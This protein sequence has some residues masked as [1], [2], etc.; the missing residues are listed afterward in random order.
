MGISRRSFL[1]TAALAGLAANGASGSEKM[2]TRILGRTGARVSILGFG[3]GSRFLMYKDEEK[4][5]AA[6]NRAL[7]LGINYVD[8]AYVYGDGVSETWV[9]QVMK[10]RRKEAWL[11]TKIHKRNGDEA[12]RIIEGSLKRL[13][14]DHVDL[15][16]VHDL[17]EDDDLKAIE[18]KDGV[19]NL[20]Y[21][22]R[23]QKVARFI[24]VT[25]HHNPHSLKAALEH[26]D[27][28]CTQMALNAARVGPTKGFA[29]PF[30]ECFENIALPVAQSKKMGITAM[31]IFGQE[32]LVGEASPEKL[33][34]YV[35]SLP[36]AAAIIGM[37]KLD[38]L[39]Q[40]V[41]V[42]KSF[43][44]MPHDEMKSLAAELSS[45][46]KLAMDRY[47]QNHVDC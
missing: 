3:C 25:C 9:G 19:L 4:G 10:T 38:H 26:N 34:R 41:T 15:L 8:S 14:T 24:G 36:V 23:E 5:V 2:P 22:L 18:A 16:H 37:P 21:K 29:N 6:L 43:K 11:V 1:G 46:H 20:L 7:D 42:A 13:Q 31:K 44:P 45:K 30:E 27:F 40:N 32:K 33:I 47:F 35:M 39:E 28:D 17:K 12:M